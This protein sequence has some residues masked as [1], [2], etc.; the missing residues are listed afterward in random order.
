MGSCISKP[1]PPHKNELRDKKKNP[2]KSKTLEKLSE[3]ETFLTNNTK[4]PTHSVLSDDVF[5]RSTI[6]SEVTRFDKN[7]AEFNKLDDCDVF[8]DHNRSVISEPRPASRQQKREV[9]ADVIHGKI[10]RIDGPDEIFVNSE[11]SCPEFLYLGED[12]IRLNKTELYEGLEVS[13]V[14]G[15]SATQSPARIV[16]VHNHKD[17]IENNRNLT[18]CTKNESKNDT[19][20]FN[21]TSDDTRNMMNSMENFNGIVRLNET[22]EIN[23]SCFSIQKRDS[24]DLDKYF[25]SK[26]EQQIFKKKNLESSTEIVCDN[27]LHLNPEQTPT[28]GRKFTNFRQIRKKSENEDNLPVCQIRSNMVN[29]FEQSTLQK[30]TPSSQKTIDFL[31]HLERDLKDDDKKLGEKA[32]PLSIYSAFEIAP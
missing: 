28:S 5:R 4:L 13:F 32:R 29:S 11:N 25:S 20:T 26:T 27:T 23:D 12:N 7:T 16:Q 2:P 15:G 9:G 24:D 1:N 18:N 21:T 31:R 17:E 6:C 8:Y 30:T 14:R 10:I 19:T 22:S 3:E